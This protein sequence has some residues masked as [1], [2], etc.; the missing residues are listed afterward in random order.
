MNLDDLK[1]YRIMYQGAPSGRFA[2]PLHVAEQFPT[3]PYTLVKTTLKETFTK[4]SKESLIALRNTVV[5]TEKR[6][7]NACIVSFENQLRKDSELQ[8]QN[9][10]E[11][12]KQSETVRMEKLLKDKRECSMILLQEQESRLKMVKDRVERLL[13][14]N[15]EEV[16]KRVEEQATSLY[17]QKIR[18]DVA[19]QL[20]ELV[21]EGEEKHKALEE[22]RARIM[23]GAVKTDS[24][25]GQASCWEA[26]GEVC[27]CSC[28][29]YN[30]GIAHDPERQNSYQRLL[31]F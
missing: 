1:I 22:R 2:M 28:G 17:Q 27:H 6:K 21:R 7:L 15:P 29:G 30:H 16:L 3:G 19:T 31:G 11:R 9:E 4:E 25:C 14:Q 10:K 8:L 12:I 20:Q 26:I 23:R 18:E 13:Q 24:P 5:E